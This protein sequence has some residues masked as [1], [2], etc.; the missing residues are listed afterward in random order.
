MLRTIIL[1]FF[2]FTS[3]SFISS[4][5]LIDPYEEEYAEIHIFRP[6][7][8]QGGAIIFQVQV[9]DQTVARLSNGSRITYRIYHE[10]SVD[11]KLKASQFTSKSV[12]FGIVKG[13]DYYIKA[14]YGDGFGSSLSF[15]PLTDLQG[16]SAFNDRSG[17]YGKK[18]KL[19][20]EDSSNPVVRDVDFFSSEIKEFEEK[21]GEKPSLGW[22]SPERDNTKTDISTFSLQ[23]CLQSEADK[24]D[25]EVYI[26]EGFI[27]E[28][29]N[30]ATLD[31]K[32][33]YTYINNIELVEG[34]NEIMVKLTDEFGEKVFKRNIHFEERK[35]E[36]RGLALV[37][38]N[39]NY[40]SATHLPN[41]EN[42]AKDMGD[43]LRKLGF[44][45]IQLNNLGHE[46]MKRA[47]GNFALKLENYTTGLFF[48]A[49]HG[50]QYNGRNYL[51]PIDADLKTDNDITKKCVDTGSLLT[52]MEL[53]GLETSILILDACRNNPFKGLGSGVSDNSLGLTG[54]DAPAGSIVA[55]ATAPGKTAS[56]GRGGNGLYTSEILK[57]I[58]KED[59]KVEDMFKRVRIN[60]MNQSDNKQIPW[61]T[62]S[63]V[64]DFYFN[65]A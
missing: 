6:K 9:N 43:A 50:I 59:L 27:D 8:F 28:K 14:G 32:C 13:Q 17:F 62:S 12:N 29:K 16:R 2:L 58:Y 24:I 34:K 23:M 26:N 18:I 31:K 64:K 49:G 53:M 61:E 60:V 42:D 1:S 63:L 30:I 39:A 65:P 25:I 37:I 51:I 46:E 41:P 45:V 10:G 33:A 20:E 15:L 11:F 40:F 54:T 44:E 57:N 19:Y 4:S 36:Y 48:Y 56:D 22:I 7:Q 55:F 3:A 35:R 5:S 47:V 21:E 38:G 52:K